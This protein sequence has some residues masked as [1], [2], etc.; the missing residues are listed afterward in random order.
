MYFRMIKHNIQE[1]L[2][3]N[4]FDKKI[5]F[6]SVVFG[7]KINKWEFN[8]NQNTLVR[9]WVKNYLPDFGSSAILLIVFFQ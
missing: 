3:D 8:S 2:W 6:G 9:E 1:S 7:K 5:F 4:R